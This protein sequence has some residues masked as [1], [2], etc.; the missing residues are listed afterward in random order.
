MSAPSTANIIE[1]SPA[2][3]AVNAPRAI[4]A[5]SETTYYSADFLFI[6]YRPPQS[7]DEAIVTGA[8][9]YSRTSPESKVRAYALAGERFDEPFFRLLRVSGTRGGSNC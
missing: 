5:V 9:W 3:I 6:G 7:C 1:T 2:N 4:L 8:S